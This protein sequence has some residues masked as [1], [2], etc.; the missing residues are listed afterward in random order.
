MYE[1]CKR[2]VRKSNGLLRESSK[3]GIFVRVCCF[4][5]LCLEFIPY[6]MLVTCT[7]NLPLKRRPYQF[8]P[9]R[10]LTNGKVFG[11]TY[12][13]LVQKWRHHYTPRGEM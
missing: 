3:Y 1:L 10:Q 11:S 5:L 2:M 8:P 7:P 6:F 9:L 12:C 4:A 13:S